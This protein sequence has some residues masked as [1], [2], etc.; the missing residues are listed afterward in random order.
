MVAVGREKKK[1]R[2]MTTEPYKEKEHVEKAVS[3]P[4]RLNFLHLMA[5]N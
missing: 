2:I 5:Y 4:T 3:F 1:K